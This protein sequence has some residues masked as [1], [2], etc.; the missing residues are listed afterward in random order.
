MTKSR[1]IGRASRVRTG[2][3]LAAAIILLS[4]GVRA[5]DVHLLDNAEIM[6]LLNNA[7]LDLAN[8]VGDPDV[9]RHHLQPVSQVSEHGKV[10]VVLPHGYDIERGIW[11]VEDEEFCVLYQHV[12]TVRKRCF[13]VAR[14]GENT[15]FIELRYELPGQHVVRPHQWVQ[16]A[17]LTRVAEG[18]GVFH[19]LNDE[20]LVALL[21][22]AHIR[23]KGHDSPKE[24]IVHFLP[25]EKPG[26]HG[27]LGKSDGSWWVEDEQF[28]LYFPLT[29]GARKRCF[30]IA[31][32]GDN[33]RVIETRWEQP[34]HVV[35][36]SHQ[37]V[38]SAQIFHAV[39][40]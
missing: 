38:P 7:T 13:A 10:D 16:T 26:D 8:V 23:L 18:Q 33:F 34:G 31:R 27:G 11:W 30:A 9:I 12:I 29:V 20:E 32:D 22:G 19:L 28:C 35:E 14:E 3:S 1:K 40:G 25:V 36:R 2:L 21:N 15:R 4:S 5:D 24:L 37:W 39:G 6:A 17:R